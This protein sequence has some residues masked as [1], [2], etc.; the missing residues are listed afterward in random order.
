MDLIFS[1]YSWWKGFQ[2]S[3]LAILSLDLNRG[4]ASFMDHIVTNLSAMQETQI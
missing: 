1:L 4:G 2:T 3:S